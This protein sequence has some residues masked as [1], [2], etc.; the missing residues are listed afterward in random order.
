M[1]KTAIP[2]IYP[3]E[4]NYEFTPIHVRLSSL[5]PGAEIYYTTDGSLPTRK[6]KRFNPDEGLICLNIRPENNKTITIRAFAQAADFEPSDICNFQYN[7][8]CRKKGT[9]RHEILREP[10]QEHSGVIRIEDYEL[11][12]MYLI[13]GTNRAVLIDAGWDE[14]GDLPG[15]CQQLTAGMPVDLVIAHGHPDHVMQAQNFIEAGSRVYLPPKDCEMASRFLPSLQIDKTLALEEGIDFDLGG[16]ILKTYAMPGHTPGSV[17]LVDESTGD[18]FSSD[19]F[20]SNRRYVCDSAFLQLTDI[21]LESVLR[22]LDR[23]IKL[24]A[25]KINRIFTG[26]NDEILDAIPYLSNFRRGLIR[27]I[28]GGDAELVPSPRA[29]SETLGSGTAFCEGDYRI[30]PVW[31]S[32]NVRYITDA[33]SSTGRYCTGFDPSLCNL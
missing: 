3:A 23:F 26:H 31:I 8:T 16:T 19:A 7:F 24:S 27:V 11:E 13:I 17:V 25:G 33:D 20:G 29:A 14:T 5:T 10:T 1:R 2:S 15:L 4:G 6:S 30:D 12:K 22:S 18:V 9:Y 32:A 28:K 21:S